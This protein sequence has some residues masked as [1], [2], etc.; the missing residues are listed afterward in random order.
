MIRSFSIGL[1]K[2]AEHLRK[3]GLSC[4]NGKRESKDH[5]GPRAVAIGISQ[6]NQLNLRLLLI[7]VHAVSG[8]FHSHLLVT[9]GRFA[10]QL[11]RLPA[12]DS[13]VFDYTFQP[14]V[15]LR[16]FYCQLTASGLMHQ[17]MPDRILNVWL[18]QE[19]WYFNEFRFYSVLHAYRVIKP[20]FKSHFF[21]LDV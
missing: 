3:Q 2:F 17:P 11:P 20:V 15:F 5:P 6:I 16:N 10:F 13:V 7:E 12:S 4:L 18:K 1:N 21:H 9:R 19:R 14:P 8:D